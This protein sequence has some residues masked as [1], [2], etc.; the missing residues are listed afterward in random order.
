MEL[1]VLRYFLAVARE[2]NITAAAKAL[3]MTQPTLSKQLMDLEAQLGK[4][5]FIRGKRKITLTEEG[6]FLRKRAQEIVE[7]ADKTEAELTASDKAVGGDLYIGAGETQAVHFIAKAIKTLHIHYPDVRYHLFSGNG[8]D[9]SERLDKGL[10]DFGL[11]VGNVES[12][13]YDYLKLPVAD[14]WGLL[15][16]RDDPLAKLGKIRP[17]DL[18]GVR[19]L[20]SRQALIQ[21]ELSGWL[22]CE[23]E[24]LHIVGT[25]NLIYNASVM[26]E[27]GMGA[28]LCLNGLLN[29]SGNSS[30]CFLPLEPVLTAELKIAWK[31]YQVFT[32]AAQKFLEVLQQT[33]AQEAVQKNKPKERVCKK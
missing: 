28:A 24:R 10:I 3:H 32:K 23:F 21:N 11:F 14:T 6:I 33:L 1:R 26:V 8:E 16:R 25:Y 13:K 22:G 20:S 4:T 19:L 18:S 17:K 29:T 30:L 5:L 31:K 15:V 27:E 9:V 2:E 12:Q 7:L